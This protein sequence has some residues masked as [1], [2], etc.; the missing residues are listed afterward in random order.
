MHAGLAF[1]YWVSDLQQ[2]HQHYTGVFRWIGYNMH[3]RYVTSGILE[4]TVSRFWILYISVGWLCHCKQDITSLRKA[5]QA[6]RP[7]TIC[8][9][10]FYSS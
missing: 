6:P 5:R 3:L 2:R 10:W 8:L 9:A 4:K 7:L 1:L